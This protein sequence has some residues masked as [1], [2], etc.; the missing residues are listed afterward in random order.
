MNPNY[1][2]DVHGIPMDELEKKQI[3]SNLILRTFRCPVC[4]REKKFV[5]YGWTG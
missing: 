2:C 3:S 4:G 1:G 5:E